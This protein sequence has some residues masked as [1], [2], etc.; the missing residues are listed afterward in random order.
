M[1]GIVY[2]YQGRV[3]DAVQAYGRAR[4]FLRRCA[5]RNDI[6]FAV[7]YHNLGGVE[8]ARERYALAERLA[9]RGLAI[10]RR[11]HGRCHPDVAA[12][13]TAL[14]AVLYGRKKYSAA[15]NMLELADDMFRKTRSSQAVRELAVID[16]T[17]GATLQALGRFAQAE[18]CYRRSLARRRRVLGEKHPDVGL[19]LNNLADLYYRLGRNAEAQA[20]S[21]RA[22][23]VLMAALGPRHPHTRTAIANARRMVDEAIPAARIRRNRKNQL[24]R[25]RHRS[26]RRPPASRGRD[27]ET[28]RTASR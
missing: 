28:A 24:E 5:P 10:R 19:A 6:A 11:Y 21:R 9:R 15:L 2:K 7:L 25:N 16:N 8:F 3:R 12:D 4:I 26:H 22:V 1:L 23:S 17:R 18:R 27:E 20:T 13:L 14:A